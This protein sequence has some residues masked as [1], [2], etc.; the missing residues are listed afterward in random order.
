MKTQK[1][2]FV[3]A[4]CLALLNLNCNSDDDDG[5]SSQPTNMELLTSGKWYFE[6]KTPG[7]YN[8]CEKNGYI[9]FMDNGTLILDVFEEDAGTCV[10][11][12]A[13]TANY[14]LTNDVN[15]TLTL[16]T[17]TESAVISAISATSLTVNNTDTGEVIIFDKTAG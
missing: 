5:S 1:V 8:D 2:L 17:D 4:L 6:S 13:V 9:Q 7:S 12:G 14:T 16:G 3:L 11:L 10:S 15:L